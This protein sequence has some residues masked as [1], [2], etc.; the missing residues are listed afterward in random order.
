MKNDNTFARLI[1]L[2]A[3]VALLVGIS[4]EVLTGD[5]QSY[6]AWYMWLQLAVCIIFMIDFAAAMMAT[7]NNS[8][9]WFWLNL[10][11]FLISIPYLNILSWLN[12]VPHRGVAIAVAALPL[13]RSFVAMG[14]VVWW[15]IAGKVSRI[16]VAY[17][18]TVVCFT[19]LAALIFYDYEVLVNEKLH[20]FGNAFWWAWMNTTTV[21][22][23][24][25]PVTT[26]GKVLAVLLP[27]LGMM[28]FPIFTIYVTNIYN[29]KAGKNKK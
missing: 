14:V 4:I 21:G 15:F 25:F 24:I 26:I 8:R 5:H 19:Y 29:V 6:S 13:L 18:F 2:I 3:G 23:A 9:R 12:V 11:F 7:D 22:A 28:F 27:S 10:L 16:F 20:G 17:L 1:N